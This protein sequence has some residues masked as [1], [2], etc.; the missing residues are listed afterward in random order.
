MNNLDADIQYLDCFLILNVICLSDGCEGFLLDDTCI[1]ND[2]CMSVGDVV[3]RCLDVLVGYLRCIHLAD[4][5]W[6]T[7]R[8]SCSTLMV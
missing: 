2:V 3:L 7:D 5:G 1:D 8:W 4:G 6:I